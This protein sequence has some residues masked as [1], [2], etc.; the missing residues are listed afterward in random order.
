MPFSILCPHKG[1]RDQMEPYL[2]TDTNLVYCSS[3]DQEIPNITH[4]VK[5][6]MKSFKQFRK[7]KTISFS[8]KCQ[9]C[10]KEDRP[11]IVNDQIICSFCKAEHAHLSEPFKILLKDKLK[12]IEQDV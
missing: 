8:V 6:Q 1:C 5:I 12:S 2:D 9:K 3:C 4:F 7:K 11:K 10:S